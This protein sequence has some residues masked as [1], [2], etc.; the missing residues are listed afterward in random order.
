MLSPREGGAVYYMDNT[1]AQ[2]MGG[3]GFWDSFKSG[4]TTFGSNVNR[5]L[6]SD[7][8]QNGWNRFKNSDFAKNLTDTALG[9]VTELSNLGVG[10]LQD[11]IRSK[12]EDLRDRRELSSMERRMRQDAK[13][14]LELR[15]LL[16]LEQ[17]LKGGI[18]H[19]PEEED[20]YDERAPPSKKSPIMTLERTYEEDPPPY[21]EV[22]SPAPKNKID[23]NQLTSK[24]GA[25]KRKHG[26]YLSM[27]SLPQLAGGAIGSSCKRICY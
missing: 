16:R 17:E 7:V 1:F 5:V 20:I 10:A 3:A 18:K 6:K 19:K 12:M 8:V 13:R 21:S 26:G 24:G 27:K 23:M 22:T 14:E 11:Q 9:T 15:R 25:I 4:W 2:H